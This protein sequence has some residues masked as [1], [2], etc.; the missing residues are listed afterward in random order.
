MELFILPEKKK[1]VR[2]REGFTL[3]MILELGLEK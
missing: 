1:E 3:Q 2:I